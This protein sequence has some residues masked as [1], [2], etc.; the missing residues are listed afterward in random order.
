MPATWRSLGLAALLSGP[1]ALTGCTG[2]LSDASG[3]E[4]TGAGTGGGTPVTTLPSGCDVDSIVA[5]EPRRLTA[6]EFSNAVFDLFGVRIDP[7][8]LPTDARV[9]G[10]LSNRGN[11]VTRTEMDP[12]I[13]SIEGIAPQAAERV[14]R[15]IGCSFGDP[16]CLDVF[17]RQWGRSLY[18][19]EPSAEER[20]RLDDF[21]TAALAFDGPETALEMTIV[22]L[23]GSPQFVYVFETAPGPSD[24]ARKRRPRFARDSLGACSLANRADPRPLPSGIS[25]RHRQSSV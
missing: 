21:A 11:P 6:N 8:N 7:G 17:L 5:P 19:R 13:N 3:F 25:A 16:G 18:H 14:S 10:F 4:P 1:L 24:A 9:G 22:A 2:V 20:Q 23:L 15:D 12:F